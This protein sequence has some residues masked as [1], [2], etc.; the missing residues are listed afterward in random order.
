MDTPLT[1]K[2]GP[3]GI[4]APTAP[5]LGS[6]GQPEGRVAAVVAQFGVTDRDHEVLLPGAVVDGTPVLVSAF[7]HDM[8]LM[9]APPA[10]KGAVFVEGDYLVFRG[11]LFMGTQ[12]GRETLEVIKALG[13]QGRWSWGFRI[14]E[15]LDP[16]P[17]QARDGVRRLLKKVAAF[18]V[19]P[20]LTPAG[21]NTR[22]LLSKRVEAARLAAQREAAAEVARFR[23]TVMRRNPKWRF[24]TQAEYE[25]R[26]RLPKLD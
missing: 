3:A 18:E 2:I 19:S 7:G 8:V 26:L 17:A 20:V 14:L 21:F 22:T 4:E 24:E 11:E 15:A 23:Q 12:R 25:N 5:A 10:G 9:A 13:G 6:A 1:M 16:T